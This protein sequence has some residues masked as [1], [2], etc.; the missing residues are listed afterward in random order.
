MTKTHNAEHLP[1]LETWLSNIKLTSQTRKSY[2]ADCRDFLHHLDEIETP[3]RNV[4]PHT[5]IE[6]IMKKRYTSEGTIQRKLASISRMSKYSQTTQD[7]H[8]KFERR[9]G[10]I[11]SVKESL[12]N[13][14]PPKKTAITEDTFQE[15]LLRINAYT[16]TSINHMPLQ[17]DRNIVAASLFFRTG[18]TTEQVVALNQ[19]NLETKE[20][21]TQITVSFQRR[22]SNPNRIIRP[23]K[24]YTASG[25]EARTIA[26]YHEKLEQLKEITNR[27]LFPNKHR[28]RIS[29]RRLRRS[30]IE[31]SGGDDSPFALTPSLLRRSFIYAMLESNV[32]KEML[33]EEMGLTKGTRGQLFNDEP[34]TLLKY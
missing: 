11:I 6:Y 22:K 9:A 33:K 16:S 14:E 26:S 19:D 30:L 18:A 27:A 2:L 3:L 15:A 29:G 8:F 13:L 5:I 12:E 34:F 23:D 25:L 28:I 20:E 17:N 24:T 4:T 7:S 10:D 1:R 32:D 21:G 31:T